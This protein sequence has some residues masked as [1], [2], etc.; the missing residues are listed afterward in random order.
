MQRRSQGKPI[1]LL[2]FFL[3][4]IGSAYAQQETSA[5]VTGRVTDA[6][7]AVIA[8]ATI[9]VANQEN[10]AVRRIQTNTE[11]IYIATPLIP[12]HYSL[13]IEHSGFKKYVQNGIALNVSDRRQL[14]IVLETGLQTETV[15][16]EGGAPLVQ[17]SPTGQ[18]L[19]S[20]TQ[21]I[22]LP[23][24]N[25]NFLKLT[26]LVP[27]VSSSL[28]DEETFGLTSNA[29]ISINGMRRNAVNYM[30]D[31]VS[32]VDVGSNITLLSTPTVDSIQEFKILTSNYTAEFGRS[33][34]GVV[35]I[36]TKGGN[37][38]F[39]GS[40]YE[41]LRNDALSANNF[42]NNRL[43]SNADGSPRGDVPTLR[44]NNFGGTFS[45]PVVLPKKIFGPFAYNETR[46]KTFFFFSEEVRRIK[47]GATDASATVPGLANRS[48]DFSA[49]LGAPLYLQADGKSNT[50]V[51]ATPLLVTDTNG[52]QIQARS[53]MIFRADGL[54]YAGNI[55]PAG[56]ISPLANALLP[57]YPA[58]NIGIS[59]FTFNTVNVNNTRQEA[60]R[61]DHIFN[62]NHRIFGRYTRDLS[63]TQ[64]P[65]GLFTN[66][67]LPNI[68]TTAT[69][70]P[71]RVFALS[72]TSVF[73]PNLVNEA[74]YNFS[75][76]RIDSNVIGR[77]R[78]SDYPG[79]DAIPQVFPEN[80]NNAIPSLA[81]SGFTT[82]SSIQGFDIKYN[83]Y[84]IRDN[85][86]W[87]RGNHS[88]KFG[89]ELT[90]EEKIENAN[91]VTQGG[92]SFDAA[93]TQGVSGA[94]MLTQTGLPFAS[95]LTGRAAS[96]QE[97]QVDL[98][99]NFKYGRREFFAQDSWKIRPKLTLDYG[100]RYQYYLPVTDKNN[101]LTSFDPA[102]YNPAAIPACTTAACSAL[103]RGTGNELNGIAV[104][105]QTSRFGRL[106]YPSDKNNF[107][108]RV[109]I[110]WSPLG[111]NKTVIRAGYGLYF[112]QALVG[113]FEQSAFTDPPFNNRATYT[114]AGVTLANPTGG[115]L[116]ALPI[117][118]LIANAADFQTP[119]VQQWSLGVQRELFRNAVIDLSYV[120]TK[121]D[122]LIRELDL[123]QPDPADVMRVG[124]TNRNNVR[125]FKGYGSILFRETSAVSRYNG[126]LSSF[127][128]RFS[129]AFFLTAA[130][131]FS[132]NLTDSTNDRDAIDRP[133]NPLNTRIEYAEARSSRPHIF[134][135]S[136]V[137]ELPFFRHNN[138]ALVRNVL[139]GWQ[140][141]GITAVNSGQPIP[142]ILADTG[143]EIRGNRP[144]MV[145]DPNGGLAGTK[146]A[147]GLP[148]IFDPTAFAIA[149]DGT[150]G[151]APRAFSRG[152]GQNQTNLSMVKN[153]YFDGESKR[154]LQFRAEG[155]NIF[156]QTQFTLIGTT[157]ATTSTLGRPAST[158]LPREFQFALKLYF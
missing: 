1:G 153:F 157:L 97:D 51:T 91:N 90:F 131:T 66:I 119:E 14:D 83:N 16:I 37:K 156:N 100:V 76:N 57:I 2:L 70:V 3:C 7:G 134:A 98:T 138:Q 62:D 22:E 27:G 41:F 115:T 148:Y 55:V 50:A 125:R 80:N 71:G 99:V 53:G 106:V 145:G 121:G 140:F 61:I 82:V 110:A 11:G 86:T 95:F 67:S 42:F 118:S 150:Y 84:A 56:D 36:V 94:I 35:T 152:P 137:Y 141:S 18:G 20:G 46:E 30:V 120:G 154:S 19:I 21:I 63:E 122:H 9:V 34:G 5:T 47:R 10:G 29:S 116:G 58:P 136:Y 144:N 139:G 146:D 96:Y 60:I 155:F 40:L 75:S 109:G 114:G 23:L 74:T 73:S 4:F 101:L 133:Q 49:N 88:F 12:G 44:Y 17:Y 112:D 78:R 151:N 24:N 124:T 127:S 135:L 130:Y 43:G 104:A 117:R 123:N 26:E 81:I 72:L 143:S 129:S 15:T 158:R 132:K 39:H 65:G 108:P 59:G 69:N 147:S 52:R 45:G 6:T 111:D 64:E 38:D 33:S 103:V 54:A 79:T 142:R 128:Y 105:D 126:L 102:L 48:G 13:T 87:T 25:R 28:N 149:A 31:G 77:G 107:S 85:L 113:I 92:F 68:A 89:G 8:G 93:A 32:N